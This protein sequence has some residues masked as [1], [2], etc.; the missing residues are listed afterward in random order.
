M[1]KKN[2][3]E[4]PPHEAAKR[5]EKAIRGALRTPPKPL[6]QMPPKRFGKSSASRT[7]PKR[8]EK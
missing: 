5:F 7:V 6:K 8:G 2:S 4:Y 3:D 1:T